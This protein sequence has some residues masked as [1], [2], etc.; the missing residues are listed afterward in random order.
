WNLRGVVWHR[1]EPFGHYVEDVTD[2]G[3][4]E[5]VDVI[6]G[7]LTGKATRRNKSVA[8]TQTRMAGSAVNVEAL[9]APFQ[10]F[11][12]YR[13]GHVVAR[14]ISHLTGVEVRVLP[15]IAARNR[16]RHERPSGPLVLEEIALGKR[17]LA[18]LHVHVDTTSRKE[19]EQCRGRNDSESMHVASWAP[20]RSSEAKVP[21]ET[22]AC[23]S[24]CTGDR[25]KTRSRRSDP[26]WPSRSAA[27]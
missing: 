7:R 21:L 26:Y 6:R 8:V 4:C 10:N 2:R 24:D 23:P 15:Q 19:R 25:S 13:E 27:R 11:L 12:R 1:A 9:A 14:I 18:W 17:V 20:P 3:F 5:P 22:A 16:S